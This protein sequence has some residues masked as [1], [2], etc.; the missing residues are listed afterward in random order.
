[1]EHTASQLSEQG[2]NAFQSRSYEEAADLFQQAADAY[3][4]DDKPLDAAEALNNLSVVLVKLKRAEEALAAVDGTEKLF[5]EAGDIKRRAMAL[6]NKAAALEKLGNT[7]EAIALYEEAVKLFHE[8]GEEDMKT[9]ALQAISDIKLLKGNF[10]GTALD[11]VDALISN[12]NPN[13]MQKILKFILR[14]F[15]KL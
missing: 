12:P 13:F 1:M 15:A 6:G 2:I 7:K 8:I 5:E 10:S 14:R 3:Q 11:A 9:A 4:K